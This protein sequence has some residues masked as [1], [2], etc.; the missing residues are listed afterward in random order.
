MVFILVFF[1]KKEQIS[2]N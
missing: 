1:I 2:S